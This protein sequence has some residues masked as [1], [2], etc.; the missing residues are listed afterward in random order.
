MRALAWA[1]LAW[2]TLAGAAYAVHLLANTV[3][4]TPGSNAWASWVM[5]R[6]LTSLG[7]LAVLGTACAASVRT[8]AAYRWA[9]AAAVVV[10][11]LEMVAIVA[12]LAGARFRGGW[13]MV[14]LLLAPARVVAPLLMPVALAGSFLPRVP[15]LRRVA[16]VCGRLVAFAAAAQ[17]LVWLY[18]L[19]FARG[20]SVDSLAFNDDP[21][22]VRGLAFGVGQ[23]A[24]LVGGLLTAGRWFRVAAAW[25]AAGVATSAA[26][27]PWKLIGPLIAAAIAMDVNRLYLVL[28]VCGPLSNLCLPTGLAWAAFAASRRA[29]LAA[30]TTD[31]V[32][33]R[34]E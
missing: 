3:S 11:S 31:P 28:T 5:W 13:W 33:D 15:R 2:A 4:G 17:L 19:V 10:G 9:G 18:V 21:G 16:G 6:W 34:G 24:L 22:P 8:R 32:P 29:R 12:E 26:T 25:L 27:A 7:S 14:Y 1:G 23:I 30:A 20:W